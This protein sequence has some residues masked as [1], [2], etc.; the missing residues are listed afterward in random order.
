MQSPPEDEE[1]QV[2]KKKALPVVDDDIDFGRAFDIAIDYIVKN[3]DHEV[4]Y[5]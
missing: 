2:P 1:P 4:E 5:D 3:R